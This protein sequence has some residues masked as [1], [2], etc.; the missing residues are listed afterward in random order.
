MHLH[1]YIRIANANGYYPLAFSPLANL[2][3]DLS[4]FFLVY[5]HELFNVEREIERLIG[6]HYLSEI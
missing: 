2:A 6:N 4:L 3:L 5:F 1:S